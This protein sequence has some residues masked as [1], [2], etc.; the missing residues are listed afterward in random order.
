MERETATALPD[1]LNLHFDN[2]VDGQY[3]LD[4]EADV[5]IKANP[6]MCELLGFTHEQLV[7]ARRPVSAL[8]LVHPDDRELVKAQRAVS[9]NIGD[10]N[11]MRFR[12][13]RSDGDVRHLECRYALIPH[14]GRLL[15]VGSARDVSEQAKLEHKLR[16]ESDFNRELSLAAQRAA[17]ESQRKQVEVVQANTREAALSEVLRAIPLLTKR[18]AEIESVDNVFKEA[19]LTMVNDAHFS[20]CMVLLKDEQGALE[21]R[22]AN[23]S[24]D[25]VRLRP[26]SHPLYQDLLTGAREI[27]VD[28]GGV[29]I[30]PIRSGTYVRGLL[31]VGLPRMLQAFYA[32]NK[33]IQESVRD[34]VVTIADFLGVV[35]QNHENLERIRQQSRVD[36]LTGLL[37]RRV[38]DEQLVIEFRRA[39][40]Y[41]RDLSLMMFDLDNFKRVNDTWG[42]QQ[43]DAVLEA[44]SGLLRGSFRDLDTVCRYGGEEI[45]VIMPETVGEAAR[46]KGEQIRRKIAEMEIPL[47]DEH[48]KC[49]G[50][51]VSVGIACMNKTTQTE[52]Q[53][54]RAADRALYYCK[55]HGKNQVRLADESDAA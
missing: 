1:L 10:V 8:S 30:A 36:Q 22:Y 18:L 23:P 49:M 38:F 21:V 5:F 7:E 20:S 41:E 2:A 34:L 24:R 25:T 46:V 37:N 54:L 11:V 52:Q 32:A 42:H 9:Q 19:V 48:K 4:P 33:Q 28:A 45:C 15:H 3:V 35:V 14:M 16:A 13:V 29:H 26:E 27:S 6:A 43:G 51:T 47:V 55:N 50:V 40:R 12:A 53:L 31:Q 17:K 44:V 39:L